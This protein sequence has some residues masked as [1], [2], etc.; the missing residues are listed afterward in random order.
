MEPLTV[1][2]LSRKKGPPRWDSGLVKPKTLRQQRYR[3]RKRRHKLQEAG[4]ALPPELLDLPPKK[5][6]KARLSDTELQRPEHTAARKQRMYRDAIAE[7]KRA[8][9]AAAMLHLAEMQRHAEQLA[10]RKAAR[11]AAQLS[12]RNPEGARGLLL[13]AAIH[14]DDEA[15][16]DIGGSERCSVSGVH[17]L[18]CCKKHACKEC[19][20][21]WLARHNC[22]VPAHYSEGLHHEESA[23]RGRAVK[24][25]INAR[26][27]PFCRA[28]ISALR[29]AF[30]GGGRAPATPS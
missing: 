29:Q 11:V 5:V 14:I 8:A 16:C 19:L 26:R 28:P 24:K 23:P 17:V 30:A 15:E 6:G 18:R 4:I 7:K 22:E 2:A 9:A 25:A 21:G 20:Q 12:E 1:V 13:A 10:A 3:D 27:C